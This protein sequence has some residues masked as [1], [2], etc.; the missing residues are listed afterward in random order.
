MD[1]TP[2]SE[3][4]T[5]LYVEADPDRASTFDRE[6][7]SLSCFDIITV[8]TADAAV[9]VLH[10]RND[11]ACIV[12][13]YELPSVDGI[14]LLET[15]R[16]QDPNVP[17]ILIS[18]SGDE[19][20]TSRAIHARVTD[21][22]THSDIESNGAQLATLIRQAVEY[23][24]TRTPVAKPDVERKAILEAVLDP[25]LVVQDTEIVYANE[26]A[27]DIFGA[28]DRTAVLGT[29]P[30]DL[31]SSGTEEITSDVLDAIQRGDRNV[32]R[33]DQGCAGL[34]HAPDLLELTAAAIEWDDDTAVFLICRDVSDARERR[35]RLR[36]FRKA[37]EAAGYAVY[38]ADTDGTIEYV[39]PAFETIT[40]YQREAA[41][42]SNPRIL[43]SGEMPDGYFEDLWETIRSGAVWHEEVINRR[44]NGE[45]Y[46]AEQTIAPI[47]D[48]DSEVDAFV[49]IQTDIT[50][51]KEQQQQLA[52]E[53]NRIRAITN[54]IPDVAIVYD[55]DGRY[56]DVLTGSEDLL[57][58]DATALIG[59]TVA[60][61]LE[62]DVA[63]LLRDAIEESLDTETVKTVEYVLDL[64]DG[65]TWFE[66]RIAPIPG[67]DREEVVMLA[68]DVTDRKE[69]ED[70]LRHYRQA[71]ESSMDLLTAVD[72]DFN[73][74]F[75]N[76]MY[77]AYHDIDTEVLRGKPVA[78]VLSTDEFET[79]K[80]HLESASDGETVEYEMT[81]SHPELGERTLD[82]RYF[83]IRD[84]NGEVVAVGAAMRDITEQ[85][86]QL[87]TIRRLSSYHKV[88]SDINQS[89]VRATETDELLDEAGTIIANSELFECASITLV[90]GAYSG[91]FCAS[92]FDRDPACGG[93]HTAEYVER[94]FEQGTLEIEDVTAAEFDQHA[95]DRPSHPG[96]AIAITHDEN[97]YGVLTVHFPPGA[98]PNDPEID[99][100]EEIADDLGLFI[101]NQEIDRERRQRERELQ[102]QKQRYESLFD[103]IRDAVLVADS[104]RRIVDCNPAFTELFGYELEDIEGK[105]TKYVYE[106][107][108]EFERMGD[109]IE[110]HLDEPR[111]TQ[112]T[113]YE[114][115]TG[116]TFPG[117]TNVFYLRNADDE[118]VGAIGL[119]RDISDRQQR[120]RQ[121]TVIDRILRH[122][123]RNDLHVVQAFANMI[124][125]SGSGDVTE[126]AERILDTNGR[127][128]D[129]V[130][131]Q[132]KIT[133]FLSET[134]ETETIDLVPVVEALVAGAT[135]RYPAADIDTDL[136]AE[137]PVRAVP[138]ID[139]AIEELIEN[140][141]VYSDA[142]RS[143]V[144]VHIERN[145]S[146]VGISLADNGPGIPEMER[147]VLTENAEEPLYHGS[148]LGLWLVNLIVDQSDGVLEFD[149]N[150][151]RGSVVTVT[152]PRA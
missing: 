84:A 24:R 148:G 123:L 49:A 80:R 16:A 145:G 77:R 94:V 67:G 1:D 115:K 23:Q 31:F 30:V 152:L 27:L 144:S 41:V 52:A 88:L 65:Q 69:R 104:E 98:E 93:F 57:V 34:D 147:E 68:R 101:R 114:K 142:E 122:N 10:S 35:K 53:R 47:V 99:L 76:E 45:L 128:R 139:Q 125:E 22:F 86:R 48:D 117:E 108:T 18:E 5:V 127:I 9:E 140:A 151:P 133:K 54:A 29:S 44:K 63:Q 50:K 96:V 89:L 79:A 81:R 111:F 83:P 37:V 12:S 28:E 134:P 92:N 85:Q 82:I 136:P 132:R 74:I 25:I 62:P 150:E 14:A 42:G 6:I 120:L 40:G 87:E 109:T 55:R 138:A 91:F 38:I 105:S 70:R 43:H 97:D 126:Y 71:V 137:C 36:Y 143:A 118:I 61:V 46:H 146:T 102:D 13:R 59:S 8:P 4:S 32:D 75:A 56:R 116:Q 149:E 15:V 66:G 7:S 141:I 73:Y 20:I 21:Y 106:N 112:V 130:N 119:I 3:R 124:R 17:F 60:E 103:N 58:D 121:I 131:E 107:E 135:E 90:E 129:I 110:T 39:N 64:P 33:L 11:I 95:T 51:R 72:T 100:L 78:D 19:E 2:R 26:R 113:T